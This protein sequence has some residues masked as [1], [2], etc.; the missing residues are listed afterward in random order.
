[1][2][3][4]LHLQAA[5]SLP[6]SSSD[7]AWLDTGDNAWQMTAATFVAL[8]SVPGL[9]VLFG[10]LVQKKWVV[11][12][13]LMTFA[14]FASVL[15]VWVLWAY[16]MGFGTPAF[17]SANWTAS[18]CGICNFFHNFIGKPGTSI[19]SSALESRASI[20]LV[21]GGHAPVQVAAG[22]RGLLPVRVRRHHTPAVPGQRPVP[23]Q[24][25]GVDHFR[26]PL[27]LVGLQRQRLLALGW[28][29]LG[30]T[31]SRRLFRW[32]CDP[33]GRRGQWLRGRRHGR[34]PF[35]EGPG[36]G[37]AAQPAPRRHRGRHR[38]ARAGTGSTEA[39]RTS[40]APMLP[41]PL[42]TPTW[43]RRPLCSRGSCGTCTSAQPRNR[44]SS[45]R[46]TAWW[47]AWWPSPLRRV[48][49]RRRGSAHR[50]H[51]LHHRVD[52]MDLPVAGQLHEKGRRRHG[53]RL[54][55]R[56]RRLLRRYSARGLCR[57]VGRG[58][59]V[60]EGVQGPVAIRAP[61]TATPNRCSSSSW[62]R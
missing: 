22:E 1:M 26:A 37:L 15:I 13:M 58:V 38:V 11:N 34:A 62:P 60:R 35:E 32:L 53:D 45:G 56:D 24:V 16:Q 33:S 54:H 39:T 57:P 6:P 51:R 18:S 27:D 17:H 30:A 47:S 10:G 59:H 41:R 21:D 28:R 61:C 3:L 9:A 5:A 20:P 19:S 2:H 40:P 44:P 8:M 50:G 36:K 12:T 29:L 25:Q 14:G 43:L 7:Q 55:P 42:S 48:R 52:G 23:H 49:E 31:G 46:S 4:L